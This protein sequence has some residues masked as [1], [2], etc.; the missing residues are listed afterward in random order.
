MFYLRDCC[1]CVLIGELADTFL[2]EA[3]ISVF[4]FQ[5]CI[6]DLPSIQLFSLV[7]K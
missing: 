1:V 2:L 3:R 4:G 6:Y 5:Q 7:L